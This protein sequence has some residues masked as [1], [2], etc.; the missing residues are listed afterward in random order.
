GHR[1]DRTKLVYLRY[2]GRSLLE[3]TDQIVIADFLLHICQRSQRLVGSFQR[4][5]GNIKAKLLAPL[6]QGMA[7]RVFAQNESAPLGPHHLRP[8]YLVRQAVGNDPV[9]MY[10]GFVRECIAADYSFVGLDR[11]AGDVRKHLAGWKDLSSIDSSRVLQ[12][13]ATDSERHH[14]L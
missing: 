6:A 8:H 12:L 13:V 1:L 9:L 2:L 3:Y 11:N 14:D 10:S 5:L 4:F 7:P